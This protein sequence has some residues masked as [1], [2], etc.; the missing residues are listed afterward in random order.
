[1]IEKVK[2]PGY[3]EELVGTIGAEPAIAK[4]ARGLG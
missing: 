2:A 4:A 3:L 1:M